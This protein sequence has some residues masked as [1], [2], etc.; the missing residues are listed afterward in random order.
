M[1]LFLRQRF[2]GALES[3]IEDLNPAYRIEFSLHGDREG[4]KSKLHFDSF[5]SS[6]PWKNTRFLRTK[7]CERIMEVISEDPVNHRE[8][9][10]AL[11]EL[12]KD[13]VL[14]MRVFNNA[15]LQFTF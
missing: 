10:K 8:V 1:G 3:T 12:I 4:F 5:E 15:M 11:A 13:P 2:V 9:L 14:L 6:D 7:L